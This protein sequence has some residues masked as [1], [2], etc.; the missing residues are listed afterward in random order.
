MKRADPDFQ[1]PDG[2]Y[3]GWYLRDAE[4]GRYLSGFESWDAVDGRLLRF[5]IEGPLFWLGAVALGEGLPHE[6]PLFRL[7]PAG[8]AWLNGRMPAELPQPARLSVADDFTVTAPLLLPLLDRYRLARFTDLAVGGQWEQRRETVTPGPTRHRITRASLARARAAGIKGE[9]ALAILRR[10]AG[11]R[12]PPKVA[13]ALERYDQLGGE[14]RVMRGAVLRVTDAATLA[15]L[16]ADSLI[17]PLLGDL[18]SAQAVVVPEKHVDRL[19]AILKDS[20]YTIELT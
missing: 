7:T 15:A 16:R 3:S 11:G 4:T 17:A 10:A 14:V 6:A 20:G 9:D 2:N 19:L 1:R 18:I 13:A 12:V 8:A 5:L